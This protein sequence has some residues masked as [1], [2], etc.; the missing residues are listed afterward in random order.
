MSKAQDE[1]HNALA[2]LS[3]EEK[4]YVLC[5]SYPLFGAYYFDLKMADFQAEMV[6]HSEEHRRSLTLCP[7]GHSKSST[8]SKYNLIRHICWNPNVRIILTMSVFEDASDYCKS[9]EHEL[10]D[11]KLLI[12]DFGVFYNPDSWTG[13][14]FTV[15]QRQH[16]DPHGTLEV[17]GTGSYK[18]KGHGC[19]IVIPDD[20]VT[21]ETSA[22]PE[23]RRKQL[24]W[25][26]MAVQTGPRPMWT[27]DKRYGLMVPKGIDWPMDAP[28]NPKPGDDRY[29]MVS[30]VGTPFHA[31]DLYW[32][33]DNDE[34]YH[35]LHLDCWTDD[36]ETKPLWD[37]FWT[38]ESLHA[39]RESMG[40]I[41]F[42]KRYRCNPTDESE[43]VFHREWFE[44]DEQHPG[45]YDRTRSYGELP[46][47]DDGKELDLFEALGFDPASGLATRFA[48]WPTYMLL[49]IVK[50]GDPGKDMR[51]V[52][53]AYRAQVGVEW[54]LDIMLDGNPQIPH[55]GFYRKYGFD[56]CKVEK[57]GFTNLMLTH[58][59]ITEAKRKGIRIE[60]HETG[61]N[62]L[63]EIGGV[64]SMEAIFRDGLVS[65]P[66]KTDRDQKLTREIV[67]QFVYF[68]FSRS[69]RR[70]SHTDYPMATW[71]AELAIRAVGK[72]HHSGRN[73]RHPGY[74]IHNSYY[75]NRQR[76]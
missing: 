35:T 73:L 22:T 6:A 43:M 13:S 39:E 16:N 34:T 49:G 74:T 50:G 3:K 14:Q 56:I 29:G 38:N 44:G 28:Y 24:S 23:A 69:G 2:S 42:N 31:K 21:E 32:S 59:R 19:E 70:K 61:R 20:V 12:E 41:N 25:Y 36:E 27:I 9:I 65:F 68:S 1:A 67:D 11:N 55:P 71:F 30:P 57:N 62:K 18:Q 60:T 64:K 8:F 26:R 46:K 48:T 52:I 75:D 76:A 53:D 17:F 7:A 51:Y 58:H 4:K 15:K 33:L 72:R 5:R 37:G 63:D 66:F 47:D 45:C 40:L 54:L 10:T